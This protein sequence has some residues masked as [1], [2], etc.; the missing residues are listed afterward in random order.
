MEVKLGNAGG[1]ANRNESG[2]MNYGVTRLL[3]EKPAKSFGIEQI[4][5][6]QALCVDV[7][8]VSARQVIDDHHVIALAKKKLDGVRPNITCAAGDENSARVWLQNRL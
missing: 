8:A 6:A 4:E 5:H 2:E 7:V 3:G 1:F